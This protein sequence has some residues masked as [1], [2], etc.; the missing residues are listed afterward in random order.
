MVILPLEPRLTGVEQVQTVITGLTHQTVSY[1]QYRL[2]P[3]YPVEG[4]DENTKVWTVNGK[5]TVPGKSGSTR[6]I[7]TIY[8][9]VYL[10]RSCQ[11]VR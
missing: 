7:V 3:V 11:V 2:H 8:H 9:T 4:T 6:I 1:H 10:D 5:V